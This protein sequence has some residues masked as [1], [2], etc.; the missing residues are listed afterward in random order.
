MIRSCSS[1][2]LALAD[3]YKFQGRR[4]VSHKRKT[5]WVSQQIARKE[6]H[7]LWLCYERTASSSLQS[8]LSILL[9]ASAVL[10]D[11]DLI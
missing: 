11:M 6:S 8:R 1:F 3:F 10:K 7:S 5:I 9:Y 2:C 4:H